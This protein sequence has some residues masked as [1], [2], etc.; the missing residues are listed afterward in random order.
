M[1]LGKA[2]LEVKVTRQRRQIKKQR[3]IA[4]N[5]DVQFNKQWYVIIEHIIH[6]TYENIY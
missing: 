4:E 2:I 1:L 5:V 6:Q 3:L